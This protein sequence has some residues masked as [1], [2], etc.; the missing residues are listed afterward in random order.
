MHMVTDYQDRAEKPTE[1]RDAILTAAEA[2]F[3]ENGYEKATTI[4]IAKA[5]GV[6]EPTLYE[7][8]QNKEDILFS[9]LRYR[10]SLNNHMAKK[11]YEI[12]TPLSKLVRFIHDHF[13]IYLRQPEFVHI[14][15]LDGIF[16]ARFYESK[17]YA[18]FENYMATLDRILDEGKADGSFRSDLDNRII[19]NAFLGIFSHT[20]LRWFFTKDRRR[21]EMLDR[22]GDVTSLLIRLIKHPNCHDE[23]PSSA[24]IR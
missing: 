6:S 2:V 21:F 11:A 4:Q 24:P 10:L 18:D 12:K 14:F 15:V 17:A 19:K 5:A 23:P 3:A 9:T 13:S 20:A 7:Y 22:I 16:N 1:K 8:F